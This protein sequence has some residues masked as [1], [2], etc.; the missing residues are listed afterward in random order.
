[1][2]LKYIFGPVSKAFAEE[3]LAQPRQA[4]DCLAFNAEGDTDLKISPG[5]SWPA[6]SARLPSGWRP[7][8]VGVWLGAP[9]VPACLWSA[10]V[11]R[12]AVANDCQRQWHAYRHLFGRCACI[13]ADAAATRRLQ[14]AGF[15]Q[16]R[17]A[18]LAIDEINPRGGGTDTA[19]T[20]YCP[21]G[22]YPRDIDVLFVMEPDLGGEKERQLSTAQL[23]RLSGR[24]RVDVRGKPGNDAY[25]KLM[26]RTKVVVQSSGLALPC[27]RARAAAG[28]GALVLQERGAGD[29]GTVFRDRQECVLFSY[30]DF[31]RLLEHY[32][33]N[34]VERKTLADAARLRVSQLRF[35]N[36]LAEVVGELERNWSEIGRE[37]TTCVQSNAD[38]LLGRVLYA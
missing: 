22:S 37:P 31:E 3:N 18:D 7:D 6:V 1:M 30:D 17:V 35:Q 4:G 28:A 24:W 25:R 11:V 19:A 15:N 32:L 10:P 12:I 33:A 21:N 38:L 5:D 2:A 23:A 36:Q 27:S 9:S 20:T 13:L 8:F 34:E 16:S 29:L 26:A 14:E